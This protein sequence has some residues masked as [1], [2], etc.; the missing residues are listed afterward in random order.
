VCN[1][2]LKFRQWFFWVNAF[3]WPHA[4]PCTLIVSHNGSYRRCSNLPQVGVVAYSVLV[5]LP[6]KM[7]GRQVKGDETRIRKQKIIRSG[8]N[9]IAHGVL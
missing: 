4:L 8:K 6:V 3:K 1:F 9:N 2:D 5:C 7:T